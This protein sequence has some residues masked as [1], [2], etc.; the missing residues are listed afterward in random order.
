MPGA[1]FISFPAVAV[2][3]VLAV[4]LV[5]LS[6]LAG[7]RAW[8]RSRVTPAERER[9]RR[10]ALATRGKL[11]DASLVDVR[12][13]VV[14]YSYD[15]RGVEY[16]A[17]QDVSSIR[18]FLPAEESLSGPVWVRYDPKNPANSIVL[19]ESWT[20]LRTRSQSE[21]PPRRGGFGTAKEEPVDSTEHRT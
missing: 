15:I 20:G 19:A 8:Q 18:E 2:T 7:Y 17:S 16:T 9:L 10:T 3:V 1:L 12:G 4:V 6:A 13:E 11:G 21:P 14:V 5:A